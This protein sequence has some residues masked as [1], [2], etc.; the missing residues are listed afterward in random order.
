[1]KRFKIG[2][3]AKMVA[4][5]LIATIL[6]CIVA[7]A[8]S[9]WQSQSDKPDSGNDQSNDSNTNSDENN[10]G[11]TQGD[12]KPEDDTPVVN[13]TPEYLHYLTG[14]ETTMEDYYSRPLCFIMGSSGPLYGISYSFLTIEI[15]EDQGSTRALCFMNKSSLPGKIGA[16]APCRAYISDIAGYFGGILFSL[17]CDDS[18]DYRHGTGVATNIDFS[19]L[20][21]YHYT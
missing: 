15:P 11:N 13:S 17:G 19:K 3:L 20:Q 12:G 14:T 9:D 18:L 2:N 21:S 4:F 5:F 7:F 8:A 1:M 10:D 16:L 6:T